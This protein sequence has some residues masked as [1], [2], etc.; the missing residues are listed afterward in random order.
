MT[1]DQS[2]ECDDRRSPKPV[3]NRF[4]SDTNNKVSQDIKLEGHGHYLTKGG[5]CLGLIIRYAFVKFCMF[6]EMYLPRVPF[7]V[8]RNV[9]YFNP[10]RLLDH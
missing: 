5:N 10:K 6:V 1:S 3:V 8:R 7:L 2:D 9:H 4:E